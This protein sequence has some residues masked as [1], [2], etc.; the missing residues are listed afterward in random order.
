MRCVIN[1]E[2][3]TPSLFCLRRLWSGCC[4]RIKPSSARNPCAMCPLRRSNLLKVRAHQSVLPVHTSYC[5][6]CYFHSR[7]PLPH[8]RRIQSQQSSRFDLDHWAISSLLLLEGKVL[9]D[10][11][12]LVWL[13]QRQF[14]EAICCLSYC[15]IFRGSN[16]RWHHLRYSSNTPHWC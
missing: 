8:H 12:H 7:T 4:H 5:S 14:L 16:F 3:K 15:F 2:S 1:T 13:L 9:L 11:I 6:N 10:P